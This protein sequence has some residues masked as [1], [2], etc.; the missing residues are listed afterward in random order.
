[1]KDPLFDT[2][3]LVGRRVEAQFGWVERIR[4]LDAVSLIK[5]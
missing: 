2:Q 1:V 3:R 4:W 5:R